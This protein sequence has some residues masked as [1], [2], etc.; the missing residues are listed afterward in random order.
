LGKKRKGCC[1]KCKEWGPL[2]RHHIL[3]VRFFPKQTEPDV[4]FLC[5]TCHDELEKI[6]PL[7]ERRPRTFYY[8]AVILFIGL[9]KP[10]NYP[11]EE[12]L[13]GAL[14]LLDMARREQNE[15]VRRIILRKIAI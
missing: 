3:P 15:G 1:P 5:R 4:I 9:S 14:D 7:G 10:K 6:I 11:A 2:T 13:K 12:Y 8:K